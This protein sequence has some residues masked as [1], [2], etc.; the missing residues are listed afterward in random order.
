MLQ[1]SEAKDN[2]K[3]HISKFIGKKAEGI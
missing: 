2:D 1:F 3:N